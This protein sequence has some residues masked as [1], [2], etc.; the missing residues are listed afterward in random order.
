MLWSD[1]VDVEFCKTLMCDDMDFMLGEKVCLF[2]LF[3][4]VGQTKE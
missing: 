1:K 3:L 4:A 2:L